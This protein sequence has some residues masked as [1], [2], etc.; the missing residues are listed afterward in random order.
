M[1]GTCRVDD[2]L[3]PAAR[4]D[5]CSGHVKRKQLDK[6]VNVPLGPRRERGHEWE[7][8]CEAAL[9]YADASD[10]DE[11]GFRRAR[12]RLRKAAMRYGLRVGDRAQQKQ[13]QV[14]KEQLSLWDDIYTA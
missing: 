5:L 14:A 1:A 4:G 13:A 6:V 2:C 8:L 7:F 11:V 10:E 12:D 3:E 9:H